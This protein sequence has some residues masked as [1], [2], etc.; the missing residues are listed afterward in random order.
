VKITYVGV[1]PGGG[2]VSTTFD[3]PPEINEQNRSYTTLEPIRAVS[4]TVRLTFYAGTAAQGDVVGTAEAH[5]RI[6]GDGDLVD[7]NGMPIGSIVTAGTIKSVLVPAGQR[8]HVGETKS[9]SFSP[10]DRDNNVVAVSG[11]SFFMSA[12]PNLKVN[13]DGTV[14]GIAEGSANVTVSVDGAQATGTIT[15][16]PEAA[17]RTLALPTNDFVYSSLTKRIYATVPPSDDTYGNC[18]VEIDPKTATVTAFTNLGGESDVLTIGE[19]GRTVYI[20]L[21]YAGGFRRYDAMTH[22]QGPYFDLG[23][24]ERGENVAED[25]AIQP[26]TNDVVAVS[27]AAGNSHVA[28]TLFD[29]GVARP[30][31][32]IGAGANR[33]VWG[34]DP[35]V[36]YGHENQTLLASFIGIDVDAQ[37]L[38]TFGNAGPHND[39]LGGDIFYS[40]GRLFSSAGSV[41]QIE[42]ITGIGQL[43][44]RDSDD[45]AVTVD[46]VQERFYALTV[47]GGNH[48]ALDYYGTRS[49]ALIDTKTVPNI[50]GIPK[51]MIAAGQN[52]VAVATSTGTLVVIDIPRLD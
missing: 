47:S 12:S 44:L 21:R 22:S 27:Y 33:V 48:M 6:R 46:P 15:V 36:F 16:D 25:I 13:A 52:T 51:R 37:G 9:L 34:A 28:V 18:I 4:T 32:L 42:E 20:G 35:A 2:D 5:V 1:R 41:A 3:R 11:G 24:S 26:G 38:T 19:D 50:P 8:V 29:N 30:K 39:R 23:T 40:N 43:P 7:D 17:V 31:S 14:T 45:Q 10:R 49:L